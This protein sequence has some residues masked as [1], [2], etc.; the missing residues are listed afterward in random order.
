MNN[1]LL[2]SLTGIVFITLIIGALWFGF[3]SSVIVM[4]IF[5]AL[6]LV[7]AKVLAMLAIGLLVDDFI[8]IPL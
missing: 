6:G 5:L 3:E 2:R 8:L 4:G 1:V 7:G